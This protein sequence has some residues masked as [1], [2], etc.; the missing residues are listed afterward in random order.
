M[1][2][3]ATYAAIK[4]AQ[5][6]MPVLEAPAVAGVAEIDTDAGREL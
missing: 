2:A 4:A 3:L 6:A 5:R 1:A